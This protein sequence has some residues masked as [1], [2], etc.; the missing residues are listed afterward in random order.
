MPSPFPGMDP[1]IEGQA[2]EEFHTAFI[3]TAQQALMPQLVPRYIAR[4]ER[5][6]IVDHAPEGLEE[7]ERFIVPDVFIV[8]EMPSASVGTVTTVAPSAL[9]EALEVVT[10]AAGK[11]KEVRLAELPEWEYRERF[12]EIRVRETG[13]LVT[14]IELLSPTNKRKGSVGWNLYLCKRKELLYSRV[15]LV[16]L[17]LLRGGERMPLVDAPKTDYLALISRWEWRPKAVAIGWSLREPLPTIPIPLKGRGEWAKLDL[18]EVFTTVYDRGGYRYLLDYN[19]PI[20]PPLS[21]EEQSWVQERLKEF[22]EM[23]R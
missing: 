23:A 17:D 4:I 5:R 18:Q 10:E 6:V 20:E 7:P 11:A 21:D 3:V 1:F 15:H 8:E 2:W 22:A 16:E 12:V 19:R 13:E 14:V 9:K